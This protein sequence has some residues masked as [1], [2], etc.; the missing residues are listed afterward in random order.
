MPTSRRPPVVALVAV[1]ALLVLV[2]TTGGAP[3][4][5][6]AVSLSAGD[7]TPRV[8]TGLDPV[9]GD[10][11]RPNVVLI[12]ADD[13]RYD[14]LQYMPNVQ[15]L[16]GDEGVEFENAFSPHPLCCPARASFLS[17]Q[18]THNHHVWS[19]ADPFGFRAFRDAQTL[20]V[21]LDEV[22]YNTGFVGK[23]LNRY[24][25]QELR[26]GQSSL[27]YVPPGWT[28][29]RGSVDSAHEAG[30]DYG[31]STYHYFDTTLNV[32]GE[33]ERHRG[34]YQT[35]LFGTESEDL[36][37]RFASS[38]NP[39]FLWSSY[40]APHD[41]W[42]VEPDD[43]GEVRRDDGRITNFKTAAR[44]RDVKDSFDDVIST[45]PGGE[46][47]EDVSGKP[48]FIR[49]LPPLNEEEK[50][51]LLEAT[52]QRAEALSVLDAEVE[53]TIDAL[54]RTGELDD[55]VVVFTSDNGYFLGEHRQ[56]LG[57]MLP[58]EPSLRVPVL[59]RG[60]ELPQGEV[61]QDPFLII[62]FA[63]TLL[64]L[65]GAQPQPSIDGVS[66]LDV[67]RN[68]DRGWTR[69][70]FTETGPR[71]VSD[72]SES[73][74]FQVP[75]DGPSALRFSQGLRT[76]RY[77]YV[78]HAS[79]ERELY[80]LRTDPEQLTNLV[81]RPAQAGVVRQLARMLDRLR[82]CSGASCTLPL[83]TNLQAP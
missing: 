75:G 18:Y 32:D 1:A 16:I 15:R 14:D 78:E 13:M 47:E 4:G 31:G 69:G 46:G 53:Q 24:G 36:I 72:I 37:E 30:S 12:M 83:P 57:K 73:E 40:V 54:E 60:P 50:T 45:A 71:Q 19:N 81:D 43:P 58:Y 33:L 22:G 29:W 63:P 28:D 77:L 39:F 44:P 20:P 64:E 34:R 41:G 7:S 6:V 25:G 55:T 61:R 3:S 38:P 80:D 51:A 8:P 56:R 52:R 2:T 42:P 65:A 82:N 10:Q 49:N 48:F 5:S 70:V 79:R 11:T 27:Y 76:P 74:N 62:D 59:M 67:A 9:I 66:L 23:Y 26:N 21:W 35:R 17:G 68:G